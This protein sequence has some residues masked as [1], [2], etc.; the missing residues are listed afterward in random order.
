[1]AH[2]CLRRL[3]Q[4][5]LLAVCALVL[6]AC[7]AVGPDFT[8][9]EV[10]WL[11]DW[12]ST[13]ITEAK[14]ST[15]EAQALSDQWWDHFSD[16]VL[17]AL[18]AEA[19]RQNTDVRTA[20]LRILEARAQLGIAGSGLYPQLQQFNGGRRSARRRSSIAAGRRT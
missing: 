1:M 7:T 17:D 19:Q 3:P 18:V 15:T 4:R 11:E 13:A 9:P 5:S 6:S 10:P 14:T 8:P 2:A 20:G 12:S 16:P